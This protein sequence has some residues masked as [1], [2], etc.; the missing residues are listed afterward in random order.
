MPHAGFR[1]VKALSWASCY[2]ASAT[3]GPPPIGAR[4]RHWCSSVNND[5]MQRIFGAASRVVIAQD[6]RW[7]ADALLV[8]YPAAQSPSTFGLGSSWQS[9]LSGVLRE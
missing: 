1:C 4:P 2:T 6:G 3:S 7:T 5:V 8:A 9:Q